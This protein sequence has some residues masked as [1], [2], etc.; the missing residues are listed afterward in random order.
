MIDHGTGIGRETRHRTADMR[1][2]FNNFFDGG[3]F[4]KDG[5]YSLFDA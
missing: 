2:D 1:I 4:E 5:S 3:G